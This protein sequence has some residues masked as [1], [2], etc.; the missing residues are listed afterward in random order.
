MNIDTKQVLVQLPNNHILHKVW[1]DEMFIP[2]DYV[3]G[4]E[5]LIHYGNNACTEWMAKDSYNDTTGE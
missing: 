4:M 2:S 1:F 3:I 5:A